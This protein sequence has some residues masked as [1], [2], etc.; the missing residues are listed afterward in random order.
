MIVIDFFAEKN[1]GCTLKNDL[2]F[3]FNLNLNLNFYS[4]QEFFIKKKIKKL[5]ISFVRLFLIN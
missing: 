1:V 4:N 5:T 3:I 2:G